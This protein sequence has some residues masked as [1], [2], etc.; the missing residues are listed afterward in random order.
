MRYVLAIVLASLF[1]VPAGAEIIIC[2]IS[3]KHYCGLGKGCQTI[4]ATVWSV[5]DTTRKTYSRCD[6]AGCEEHDARFSTPGAY[7]TIDLPGTGTIAKMSIVDGDFLE[8]AT[9]TTTAYVSFGTCRVE[10]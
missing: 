6:S 7:V 3:E 9:L 10:E 4:A 5:I 8:V 1:A 2:E